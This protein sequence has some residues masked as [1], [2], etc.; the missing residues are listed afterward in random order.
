M[1]KLQKILCPID[2]SENSLEALKYA[3]HTALKENATVYLIHIVDSR[4]YDYGGPIYE[5]ITPVMKPAI[6]QASKDQL[7]DK[8]LEKVPKEIEGRVETVVSFGV[9][10]VE[11]IKAAR[12]YDIDLIIM[13]T[14]G[15]SG[16]SHMLIGSVAEKVVRKA[17]CPVLTVR[18]PGR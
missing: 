16:V 7:T 10:F 9:P 11:I 18:T 12:D 5:P 1:V 4:V 3:A 15:R 14:R 13:G 17:P 6:D 2:F 8:L